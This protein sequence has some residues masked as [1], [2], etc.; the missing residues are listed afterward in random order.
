MNNPLVSVVIPLYNKESYILETLASVVKQSYKNI[1]LIIIDD[2]SSDKSVP[3]ATSFLESHSGRFVKVVIR[4]R[5]NTGQ[6][7]ARNEGVALAT[8]EFVA[9]L[10]A[11]DIWHAEKIEKQVRYLERH[12][13]ID[14]V[15]CNYLM[16]SEER[17]SVKAIHFLPI[18]KKIESWLLTTGFG[19]LLESTGLARRTTLLAMAGF[20]SNLQMCGGLDLAFRFSSEGRA[21]CISEYLCAYR[22]TKLGWHNNKNDLV[23]S[24]Q[25]LLLNDNLYGS[26][27]SEIRRNLDF[28]LKL[29]SFR[30]SRDL[31]TL[32]SLVAISC[33]HPV[34]SLTYI[35]LTASR[36][37]MAALRGALFKKSSLLFWEK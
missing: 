18:E 21:G 14:L 28:H 34:S 12:N 10:D 4:T 20:A 26:F 6:T 15:L 22:V 5:P 29:W 2:S 36:V 16:F 13:N 33:K 35:A 7:A 11:D 37:F 19:G 24:Y 23:A 8:G 32:I 17:T 31:E 27:K 30:Q 9:F 1:E 25:S 3:A